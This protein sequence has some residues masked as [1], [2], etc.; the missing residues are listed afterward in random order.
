MTRT[1]E[2]A[3]YL[4]RAPAPDDRR[5]NIVELTGE[6]EALAGRARQLWC[7]LAEETVTG[8]SG[9]VVAE[10][11]DLLAALTGNVDTRRSRLQRDPEPLTDG[12]EHPPVEEVAAEP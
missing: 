8:L 5:A 6:G 11:P 9:R 1:L 4:R 3:G 7:A 12:T 10:L 2:A